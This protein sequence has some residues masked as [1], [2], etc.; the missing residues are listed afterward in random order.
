MALEHLVHADLA[1]PCTHYFDD[2]T[3]VAPEKIAEEV[4]EMVRE[5]FETL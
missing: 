3:F 4:D 2:F 1:V 5:F